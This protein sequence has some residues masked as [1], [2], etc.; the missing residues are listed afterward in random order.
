MIGYQQLSNVLL[1]VELNLPGKLLLQR[2]WLGKHAQ[3]SIVSIW[4]HQY[5]IYN[6]IQHFL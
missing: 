2:R 4:T 1:L 5:I 3:S 6:R